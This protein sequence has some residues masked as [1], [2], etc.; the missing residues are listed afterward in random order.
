MSYAIPTNELTLTDIKAYKNAAIEAGIQ[1]AMVK[2]GLTRG[3]EVVREALPGIDFPG[4][5]TG[6]VQNYITGALAAG[7]NFVGNLGAAAVLPVG[8]VAVFYK[9]ADWA[10]APNITAVAFRVGGTGASQKAIFNIQVPLNTKLESEVYLS[11]PVVYDP[12]D[13][14]FIQC[15]AIAAGPAENLGFGCFIIEKVGPNVS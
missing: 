9:I 12:Q 7:W 5:Y 8:M 2:L 6:L 1:R 15:Y 10:A 13:V 11:E 4:A 3:E 14:L